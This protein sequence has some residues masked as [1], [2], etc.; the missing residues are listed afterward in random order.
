MVHA[1]AGRIGIDE[2]LQK[3]ADPGAGLHHVPAAAGLYDELLRGGAAQHP[4]GGVGQDDDVVDLAG[5]RR[6]SGEPG[7]VDP[8]HLE[9][10]SVELQD[11]AHRVR[12]VEED[13]GGLRPQDTHLLIAPDVQHRQVPAAGQGQIVADAVL[14][15]AVVD[16]GRRVAGQIALVVIVPGHIGAALGAVDH[17]CVAVGLGRHAQ[18]V[19]A[20][21]V[22]V[23]VQ[24]RE[25]V[26]S[27]AVALL[28]IHVV[29]DVDGEL[30]AAHGLILLHGLFRIAVDGGD[31]GHHRRDADD[32]AQHGQGGP[33]LLAPDGLPRHFHG[34]SDIHSQSTSC[35]RSSMI[36]P[37]AR[38]TTRRA[39]AAMPLSWVMRMTVLPSLFS[40]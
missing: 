38:R 29:P 16:A 24:R 9:P 23:V 19:L 25:V 7:R 10:L 22:A 14:V 27:H 1:V 31:D 35:S 13:P 39:V 4:P 37:S 21:A 15:A 40:S 6:L 30:V 32:D 8:H 26:L 11:L 34:L 33:A 17:R 5:G 18:H 2:S 28:V 3:A 36:L 20:D 12:G